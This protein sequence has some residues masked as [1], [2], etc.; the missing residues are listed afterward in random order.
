MKLFRLFPLLLLCAATVR[1]DL[2]DDATAL[3][4]QWDSAT[5]DIYAGE[6]QPEAWTP[7]TAAVRGFAQHLRGET[8]KKLWLGDLPGSVAAPL[9]AAAW[10]GR[11][12]S[13]LQHVCA[14]E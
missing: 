14:L 2:L 5:I 11:R 10:L 7:L 9:E 8:A 3:Q 4:R 12:Q 6:W 1:A 13:L